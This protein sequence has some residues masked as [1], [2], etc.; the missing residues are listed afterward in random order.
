MGCIGGQA[1]RVPWHLR[2]CGSEVG[3]G[4]APSGL[5]TSHLRSFMAGRFSWRKK[6]TT[7]RTSAFES[8]PFFFFLRQGHAEF[9]PKC[10]LCGE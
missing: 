10:F 9:G 1:T 4:L 7:H 3:Y 2:T 8:L 5:I 6:N